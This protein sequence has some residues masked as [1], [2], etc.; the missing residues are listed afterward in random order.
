MPII[1][2]HPTL[3][4]LLTGVTGGLGSELLPRLVRAY[5]RHMIVALIRGA[6]DAMVNARLG[7]AV[8]YGGLSV[9][10]YSRVRVIRGDAGA[11]NLGLD[12][13]T[14]RTL[15]ASVVQIFHLAANVDFDVPL[16]V[17]RAANV[18]G[19]REVLRFA[20]QCVRGGCAG[21]RLNF[22]STAFV[23]GTRRGR[24][25]ESELQCAQK[26]WNSYEQ[27]KLEAEE[28]VAAAGAEIPATIFRPSQIIGE[29]RYGRIRKFFGFYEFVKLAERGK[30]RLLPADAAARADMAPS[31]YICDAM[32][33]FSRQPDA[34]GRTYH[35]AAGLQRSISVERVV[36]IVFDELQACAAAGATVIR[37]RIYPAE[38][39]ETQ[40]APGEAKRYHSSALKLLMRTYLPY[41]AYERDFDVAA[42][43][44]RLAAAGIVMAPIEQVV[45]A[46][47]RYAIRH[48]HGDRPVTAQ[49]AAMAAG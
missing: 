9:A 18:E 23:A 7:E 30:L 27:A 44:A 17:S 1:A 24:L 10:E 6:S 34:V 20:R 31:D 41:L 48:R 43:Q 13:A 11:P 19:T 36:D 12:N 45:R 8:A 4:I 32:L 35:L 49:P 40:A 3:S 38:L 22:V 39:L 25:L 2:S 33:Y 16:A 46:S 28:L 47:T 21:F 37:P 42:T 14:R 29:S 5:P 26:F 15:A